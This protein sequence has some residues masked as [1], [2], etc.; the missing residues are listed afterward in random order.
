ML[1]YFGR[2]GKCAVALLRAGGCQIASAAPGKSPVESLL[3]KLRLFLEP[4]GKL[5]RQKQYSLGV[6]R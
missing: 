2:L 5:I 3:L 1:H 6:A 4:A